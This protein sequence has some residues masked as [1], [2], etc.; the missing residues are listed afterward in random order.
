L[1]FRPISSELASK[2]LAKALAHTKSSLTANSFNSRLQDALQSGSSFMEVSRI[3]ALRGPNLWSRQT[4]IEAIVSCEPQEREMMPGNEF[5]KQL[6]RIFPAVGQLEG[7]R[8]GQPASMAHALEKITLSLQNQAGCPI[9]FSRTTATEEEGVYQVVVQYTEEDVGRLALA[10]AEKLCMAVKSHAAF[11]L[12]QALTELRDLDEDVRLGPSTGS[13]VDAAILKGIPYRRLTEGSMVQF[14][15]GS[16]QRR[17][18]AAETDTTSAIAESI[19]QDKDL[20][21]SLLLAAGVPVPIGRPAK[22]LDDAW[23]I[24][25]SIGLPIVVKPQ[26]GNQGKGVTVNIVERELFNQAYETAARYGEVLVEKFLPGSDYRL[27]VVGNKLVAAARREP[28]LVVGDG[29]HT[30]KELVDKVNADPRRGDGHSTS[31]T[32]IKFDD[33][34]IG[35][36]KLQDMKPNS[37][38]EKGRRVILRNNANL[39]TGGTATDVTDDVHA[40]VAARVVVA[41]QM[42]GV[43]ICG[44]DVVC[45]SVLKPLEEQNGGIVEVNAAPGLRMHISPSFGKGRNVGKAIIDY[46]YPNGD[47]GRIPVIAVTGTNGKTT[48]VRLTAHL[49]KANDLR[50]GMTNT[51]GVYVN[52]RQIDDGDCSGPRSARNVLMHPDVDAA[53]FETARGGLLREGLAFDRCQ[54]AIVTNIGSGDHLGLNYITTVED[55][56]VL[57]R[58]VVLNVATDGMAVLNATDPQVAMMARM[59]PGDVTFFAL[60]A[61]HPVLATHRAQGKRVVYT[62]N[63]NIVAQ[64]GKKYF[65]IP[66]SDIPL[67]RQGQIGFQTE[68]VMAAVGA[69]W[70]LNVPWETI[71]QGLST[72]ISDIQG[73]PGRFN[74]FDYKGATLIADYGHNPDAIQAL[75]H[76]VENMPAQ[77]R[78][79]VISG[80]GDRRDQDIRD[81]T[82]ILGTAFDEVILYQ[83]ACQR[84]RSDGEVIQLLRDG[85]NGAV[86]TQYVQDIQGEFNAID[87]ALARLSTGDLCLI[88]I[89]QV[90]AALAYIQGKVNESHVASAN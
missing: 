55:L 52:G 84:G 15:W 75:V 81:Q 25:Q 31:L 60:D 64:Q 3:R 4:S 62:E 1:A 33:I 39:S 83:D 30:V 17:I 36:L 37:V 57:K 85:L 47:N 89:D 82:Q 71:A 5:E 67:T 90:E 56:S 87:T 18:Q 65:R 21:K 63:G 43:D 9:T 24:A 70:A 54:V 50:V 68:N 29:I 7:S 49:L 61:H 38:P 40:E 35:R 34:A 46:M 76:A 51:D 26:D 10:W 12:N 72:F 20:T 59:C 23:Q 2:V 27:L 53:V 79:V 88:L 45:E 41:A 11:D 80:A 13:I 32:K 78:V 86:R 14:G 8:P 6:R 42:V 19:A 48:T 74:V 73:V 77:K 16:K 44:V 66:L 69:A 22:N 28:P 58:V